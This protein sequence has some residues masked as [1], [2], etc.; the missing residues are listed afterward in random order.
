MRDGLKLT[1]LLSP[2][3]HRLGGLILHEDKIF[4]FSGA[5][6]A[7]GAVPAQP[8]LRVRPE[9]RRV[10][11]VRPAQREPTVRR[12]DRRARRGITAGAAGSDGPAP[13]SRCWAR[14]LRVNPTGAAADGVISKL[15]IGKDIFLLGRP[16]CRP[17]AQPAL[18]VR[19][20]RWVPP[21]WTAPT[22]AM[23]RLARQ[24]WTALDDGD[25]GAAVSVQD[26]APSEPDE[27]D[28]WF[29]TDEPIPSA[30]TSTVSV[31]RKR[32]ASQLK[33]TFGMTPTPD[34]GGCG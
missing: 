7:D 32:R 13:A 2:S 3:F 33:G 26:E 10:R 24:A 4:S 15:G 31:Q 27:G 23:A 12:W 14:S 21:E 9:D 29:D 19:P 1:A 30:L 18:R 22:E 5:P 34:T 20:E 11:R 25:G 16:R 8:A 17:P 28:I 6:G